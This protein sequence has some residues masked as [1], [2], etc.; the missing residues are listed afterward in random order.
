MKIKLVHA[1]D[2]SEEPT[3]SLKIGLTEINENQ[4]ALTLTDAQGKTT[5]IVGVKLNQGKLVATRWSPG[6]G[7]NQYVTFDSEHRICDLWRKD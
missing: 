7:W 5:P 6:C 2:P 4:F 1:F 3:V